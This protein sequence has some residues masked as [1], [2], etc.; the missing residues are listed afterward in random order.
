MKA[1]LQQLASQLGT[2]AGGVS[3]YASSIGDVSSGIGTAQAGAQ[4][5]SGGADALSSGLGNL[6]TGASQL[7][8]GLSELSDASGQLVAGISD[9]D[10]GASQLS[11][12]ASALATGSKQLSDSAPELTAG[13]T[14]IATGAGQVNSG[15][16]QLKDGTKSL[17]SGSKTLASGISTLEDGADEVD[18]GAKKLA[19][20]TGTLKSGV[21]KLHSGSS[22]LTLG[23]G[24]AQDGAGELAS[25]LGDAVDGAG[26][27]ADGLKDGQ[28]DMAA[29]VVNAD[30]K[31]SMMSQPVMANGDKNTGE[32]IT[33]V[34]NYGTGF[35]PYFI[36]LGMWVGALMVSFLI[37]A[38]NNRIL[39]SRASSVA[40]VMASYIPMAIVCSVQALLL[41]VAIQFGLHMEV[42]YPVAFY[43]F[44]FLTAFTFAA[45]I[46]FF[47]ASLGTVGMVVIVVLLMLQL[48]TAAGTFPIESELPVFQVLNPILPMTYV[49]GG[50][51]MAM[52]GLSL[53]Y[54]TVDVAALLVFLVLFLALTCLLAIKKRR[55]SMA[56]LYPPIQLAG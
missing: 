25:G 8:G 14:A 47:R 17:A 46:Q 21:D 13:I 9:L 23:L 30:A 2:A 35:A 12:G 56:T 52:A 54:M 18:K 24:D 53:D 4:A 26:D 22:S 7:E 43:L 19:G 50:F 51:R 20:S 45:I 32:N 16:S 15:A 29:S 6:K 48:C 38:L 49:V 5:L 11:S 3:A 39:M 55:A 41:L 36:G 28:K 10:T 44:G 42:K 34:A 27:L 40:A 37:S 33:Q 31:S 1:T